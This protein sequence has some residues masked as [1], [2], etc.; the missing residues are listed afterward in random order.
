MPSRSTKSSRWAYFEETT[1]GEGPA[2]WGVSGKL[3][4]HTIATVEAVGGIKQPLVKN[5]VMDAR[6]FDTGTETY[7]KG[8]RNVEFRTGGYLHGSGVATDDGG[9]IALTDFMTL[10][11]HCLGGIHRSNSTT[12]T[13][14]TA[15]Q[16]ELTAVTNIIPGC[17]IGFEDITAP[18]PEHA[19]VMFVRRVLEVDTLTVTLDEEL[20][21]I[22]AA[23]D[24]VHAMATIYPH[25][26]RIDM[27]DPVQTMSHFFQ[28]DRSD[29]SKLWQLICCAGS[30]SLAFPRGDGPTWEINWLAANFKQ[31]NA[32]GGLTA[33]NWAGTPY[34][35]AP[36][37]VGRRTEFSLGVVGTTT[38]AVKQMHSIEFNVGYPA[39]RDET[40]T[41]VDYLVEGTA[42][43]TI[44][45]ENEPNFTVVTSAHTD[46]WEEDLQ[47][48]V[49]S[50]MRY[51]QVA[52]AGKVWCVMQPRCQFMESPSAVDQTGL[53]GSTLKFVSRPPADTIGGS[54]EDLQKARI[55]IGIG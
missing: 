1:Q 53:Y 16:P 14:G 27:S 18:E 11:K 48:D 17:F 30:L 51:Q 29:T 8:I 5:R 55:L 7:I 10:L 40:I 20:P 28:G 3:M 49:E 38:S 4:D 25:S 50:R 32:D 52:P 31:G 47:D 44:D 15:T 39:V 37:A 13:G 36:H 9:Q 42:R 34:G 2:D 46:Q 6:P 22:P 19:G 21:F 24:K 23:T 33:P 54:N 26:N 35:F 45:L 41:E 12:I 43:Y